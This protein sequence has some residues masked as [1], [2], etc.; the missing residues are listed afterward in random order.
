MTITNTISNQNISEHDNNFDSVRTQNAQSLEQYETGL[1]ITIVSL[2]KWIFMVFTTL[3][4][5]TITLILGL[6][7]AQNTMH[8]VASFWGQSMS[9]ITG[10]KIHIIGEENLNTSGSSLLIANHQS[11]CDIFVLY[12][13]LKKIQFRWMAKHNLFKLPIVGWAMSGAGYIPVDRSNKKKSMESMFQ[14]ARE[15]Q[16]G[17]SV[18]IFPE[19]T[20]GHNDGRMIPF[21]KGAFLLAKKS[22]SMIQPISQFGANHIIPEQDSRWLPRIYPGEVYVYIHPVVSAREYESKNLEEISEMIY[23]IIESPLLEMHLSS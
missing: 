12:S 20:T 16:A 8:K 18:I 23:K 13:V 15:I 7:R 4:L 14:A 11:M 21:K 10:N 5:G 3:N 19:G 2:M 17:K 1:F 9:F 6:L 22:E